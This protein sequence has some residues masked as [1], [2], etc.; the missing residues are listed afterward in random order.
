MRK[1]HWLALVALLGTLG[2]LLGVAEPARSQKAKE[3]PGVAEPVRPQ[4]AKEVPQTITSRIAKE[5]KLP[6]KD[7]Q[8][9]LTA[10]G[11]AIREQ[12][13]TGAPVEV[14]GL[15]TFRVVRIPEHRDLISGKPAT[16]AGSNYVEFLPTAELVGAANA[17][18]AVPAETVP[19][20]EYIIDPYQT[21]GMR[22]GTTRQ[23][24][25]RTR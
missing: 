13:R 4:R 23:Q 11:P 20:F 18:G 15:G 17:A 1:P 12:M 22:V 5:T 2:L 7:V 21:P 14:P 10:L 19:P 8:K 6:E 16:V 9:M 24:G 25:T 3:I